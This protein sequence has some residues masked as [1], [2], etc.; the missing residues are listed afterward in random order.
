M[1][2]KLRAKITNVSMENHGLTVIAFKAEGKVDTRLQNAQL[3][4]MSGHFA[5]K[6]V[7]AGEMKIGSMITITLTD[8]EID[9]GLIRPANRTLSE[10]VCEHNWVMDGHNAG[11]PICSKCSARE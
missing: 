4:T 2:A 1:K 6:D 8:E 7:I 3:T 9:E 10:K 11:D 5:I